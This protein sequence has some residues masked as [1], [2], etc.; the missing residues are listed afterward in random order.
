MATE[1]SKKRKRNLI[2]VGAVVLV[3]VFVCVACL[4]MGIL[5]S[6]EELVQPTVVAF[7]TATYV[8]ETSTPTLVPSSVPTPVPTPEPLATV[9]PIPPTT[10]PIVQPTAHPQ[11]TSPPQPTSGPSWWMC[12]SSTEGA[13]YVGSVQSSSMKFHKT[14]CHFVA[15]IN[16]ANRIC[17]ANRQV[18]IDLGYQPCKICN[19]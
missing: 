7:P 4:V 2:I 10:A 12:P 16:A 6:D 5:A 11:P 15:R 1:K 18:A 9:T 19:P 3:C 13:V 17:F 14:S 8:P